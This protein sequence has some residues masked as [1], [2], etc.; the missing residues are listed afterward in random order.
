VTVPLTA[1]VLVLSVRS[2]FRRDLAWGWRL[3][4]G[5]VTLASVALLW[6][7]HFWNL[8]AF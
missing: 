3:H 1:A 7:L 6:S 8:L 2:W 5:L 4:Y